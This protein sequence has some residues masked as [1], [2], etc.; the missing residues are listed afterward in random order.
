MQKAFA[1]PGAT[2]PAI[3]ISETDYELIANHAIRLETRF[4][5][6]AKMLFSEIDRAKVYPAE[7]LPPDVV[8]L[9]SVVSYSDD[10]SGAVRQVRLVVPGEADIEK[11]QVSIVTPV[12]VGLIGLKAGQSIDWPCP[13]GRPRILTI[14]D[15][16]RP[17]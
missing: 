17:A 12:G 5:E 10:S 3:Q 2:K 8:T 13:D 14:L 7:K 15:V 4:P 9:G 1:R 11:G 6:Q 16:T